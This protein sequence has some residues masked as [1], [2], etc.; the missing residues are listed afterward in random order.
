MN[1]AGEVRDEFGAGDEEEKVYYAGVTKLV[2]WAWQV[3]RKWTYHV[4]LSSIQTRVRVQP[5]VVSARMVRQ[6]RSRSS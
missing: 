3:R 2:E 5:K 4:T 1:G 6:L